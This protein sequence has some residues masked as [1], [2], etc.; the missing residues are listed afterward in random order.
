MGLVEQDPKA[1]EHGVSA[2]GAVGSTDF[3]S[4]F[5]FLLSLFALDFE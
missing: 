3:L 5:F 1:W 2:F 4:L